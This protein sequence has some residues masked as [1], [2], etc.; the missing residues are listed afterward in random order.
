[1]SQTFF[2]TVSN[3]NPITAPATITDAYAWSDAN[4]K[5]A[6]LATI[7]PMF[8]PTSDATDVTQHGVC[9]GQHCP[10]FD[11]PSVMYADE[12]A[13]TCRCADVLRYGQPYSMILSN[14]TNRYPAV[15][16]DN[17]E[18]RQMFWLNYIDPTASGELDNSVSLTP[19]GDSNAIA[20][21]SNETILD[22]I[23]TENEPKRYAY[24]SFHS[25]I[26]PDGM[27]IKSGPQGAFYV[28]QHQG[29]E[30][31]GTPM[32]NSSA[33]TV[34]GTKFAQTDS[35]LDEYDSAN[36]RYYNWV[37]AQSYDAI[38]FNLGL[39]GTPGGNRPNGLPNTSCFQRNSAS[40]REQASDYADFNSGG[41][42][43]PLFYFDVM[44]LVPNLNDIGAA[45]LST[46]NHPTS[47]KAME[48][49]RWTQAMYNRQR[50]SKSP[51]AFPDQQPYV[52]ATLP[53]AMRSTVGWYIHLG[54]S[55]YNDCSDV[56]DTTFPL[57]NATNE[58]R[59]DTWATQCSSKS[60]NHNGDYPTYRPFSVFQVIPYKID[61]PPGSVFSPETV[62][63]GHSV[64]QE[65]S[66]QD[67]CTNCDGT[68]C[69][70]VL[71]DEKKPITQNCV[72]TG[73]IGSVSG[74]S[75]Y[76]TDKKICAPQR[77]EVQWNEE[78]GNNG[79]SQSFLSQTDMYILGGIGVL[80]IVMIVLGG[81]YL[82]L[83]FKERSI[84]SQN[85]SAEQ[86]LLGN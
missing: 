17:N 51:H 24:F 40:V 10:F 34:W 28:M 22:M 2:P 16:A 77:D 30:A 85:Q 50:W 44:W 52:M 78:P 65:C 57:L 75:D 53:Y 61:K 62:Y 41:Q 45:S 32:A 63:I 19:I 12:G 84:K 8:Q 20:T 71:D 86:S 14:R 15:L 72:S 43:P 55:H 70:Q 13:G 42:W 11:D 79:N 74:T 58:V 66:A 80:L 48:D 49:G 1:M 64:S 35:N 82:R 67:D 36:Y 73:Y 81:I 56:N 37:C 39:S 59:L 27:P 5:D 54:S 23:G 76:V 21:A 29:D 38:P 83:H 7:F 68:T 4:E 47:T 25:P 33:P 6:S 3:S 26:F 69:V 46:T 60:D 18:E 31:S 9:S